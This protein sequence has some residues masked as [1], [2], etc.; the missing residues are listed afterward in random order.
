MI[1]RGGRVAHSH[2]VLNEPFI[3]GLGCMGH[4]NTA[5][6]VGFAEDVGKGRRVVNVETVEY[7]MLMR[8]ASYCN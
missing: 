1:G 5:F 6:E 8:L 3:D 4:E 7:Q 2:I